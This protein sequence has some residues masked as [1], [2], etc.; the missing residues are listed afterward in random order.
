MSRA[1]SQRVL[2]PMSPKEAGWV[3]NPLCKLIRVNYPIVSSNKN[4]III[5]YCHVVLSLL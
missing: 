1:Q 2:L 5:I 3:L 4:R